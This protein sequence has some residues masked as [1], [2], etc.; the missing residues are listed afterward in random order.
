MVDAGYPEG[1]TPPA[2]ST[3]SGLAYRVVDA[4]FSATLSSIV[5]VSDTPTN[6]LHVYDTA[7]GS[8][9]AVALP[10][11]PVAVAVDASGLVAAVAYDAHVSR[12]DLKAAS[13]TTTCS[14]SS[15]AFDV[16]LSSKGIAYV[17]PRTDQWVALHSIDLSSCTESATNNWAL[18]AGQHLALHPSEKALFAADNG[19]SPS[20]IN[21][22]DL[23]VSPIT[24]ADA[25][26]SADWGTYDYCGDLWISTD[27]QRIYSACG[28]TLKVPGNVTV[29]SCSYGGTLSGVDSIQHLSEA[30][31]AQ[32]V[33]LIPG[34]GYYYDPTGPPQLSDTVVRVHETQYL[35]FVAQYDIPL[36]PLAGSNKAVPHGKFVFAT[37]SMDALY[38]I[39]Q[40]D[41]SSGALNDFAIAKM[42]P[43]Q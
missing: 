18:Y 6:A 17:M 41:P 26:G 43:G 1:S 4:K 7:T 23:T 3:V 32:R 24:C 16:A 8:D 19:L 35:G 33:A 38:V 40:A 27:G 10:V 39:M 13:V 22:C 34:T 15:D 42:V 14:V 20:R 25:E 36:F 12:V 28:V 30:P 31:Q 21:R 37:P 29:D 9:R 5:M 2:S 11:P